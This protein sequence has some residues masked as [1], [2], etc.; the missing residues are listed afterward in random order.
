ME[1]FETGA[2]WRLALDDARSEGKTIGF[3][4]TMGALHEGHR[5]LIERARRSCDVVAV[6]IFVNPLQFGDPSDLERYPRPVHHDEALLSAAGCNA[7]FMPSVDEMYPDIKRPLISHEG[8][9]VLG[10]LFEGVDRPGHFDG[11]ATVVALLFELTGP[12]RAFFGNKDFQ[13]LA[14]VRR[15]VDALGL[16]VDIVA[17]P[18]IRDEGGLALSSRNTRL[19][20]EGRRHATAFHRALLAGAAC[21]EQGGTPS[22]V[23][24]A[25]KQEADAEPA[26]A[27]AYA[28]VVEAASFLRPA[29]FEEAVEYRLLIAGEVEGVRLIDNAAIDGSD[30]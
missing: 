22:Q 15:M 3:V 24:D 1:R 5:S 13:Q 10:D 29:L 26:L 20:R 16:P 17:C 7:L 18:T 12:C 11:V 14:V 27:L 19:S 25:M 2:Q 21:F 8:V 6:S 4:P 9:G 28:V 30:R 23:D